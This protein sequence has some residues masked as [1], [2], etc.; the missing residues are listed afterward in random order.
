MQYECEMRIMSWKGLNAMSLLGS[1]VQR[2]FCDPI[3]VLYI[4]EYIYRQTYCCQP[5][6]AGQRNLL[7]HLANNIYAKPWKR[8]KQV[9]TD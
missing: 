7:C 5:L 8:D 4:P 9:S 6:S 1:K 2:D 3:V